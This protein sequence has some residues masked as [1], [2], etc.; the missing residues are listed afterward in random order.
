MTSKIYVDLHVIQSVPP[1]CLNRDDAGSPKQ[2]VYGGARRARVSSQ[3]WKRATRLAFRDELA[4]PQNKL[5]V[6]TTRISSLLADRLRGRTKID[7]EAAGRLSTA[8][9]HDLKISEGKNAGET[10]YLLFFGWAQLDAI[11]DLVAGQVDELVALAGDALAKTVADL[12]VRETLAVGHS[13]DVALFG[14]MVADLST[15]NVEAAAQVAHAISTH[16]AEIEFDYF[17]A[18]D[19]QPRP[20]REDVGASMIGTVEFTSAT[21]YRYA[22]VGMHQLRAN[23]GGDDDAAVQALGA[24]IQALA[25]SMPTGHQN[26]FAHRTIPSL[27]SAVVRQDQPVNLV[28]AFERPVRSQSGL[29]AESTVRLARELTKASKRWGATPAL[30]ATEYDRPDGS[31][32][33]TAEQLREAFGSPLGLDEVIRTVETDVRTRLREIAPR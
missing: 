21:L 4:I 15:L 6:R 9:L 11:V 10:A 33:D 31:S 14:R 23:L 22:T 25:K 16:P 19:D 12:P 17:T 32:P 2:A 18:V 8:L 26:T 28:S 3:A 24:F 29:V 30:V 20:D 13:I 5:G 27:V 7:A 1:S